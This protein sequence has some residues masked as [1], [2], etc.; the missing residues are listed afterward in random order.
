MSRRPVSRRPVSRWLAGISLAFF[1]TLLLASQPILPAGGAAWAQ[2]DGL[3]VVVTTD[4]PPEQIGPDRTLARTTLTVVDASGQPVPGAYL[5]LHLDA[6][7][8]NPVISTDFPIVEGTSLL[9]YAGV[10]PQG[11]LSFDYIYAIRGQYTFQ[12]EAGRDAASLRPMA[13]FRMT[14]RE[15][16]DEVRN[17]LLLVAGLFLFG[18]LAGAIIAGGAAAQSAVALLLL[19]LILFPGMAQAHSNDPPSDVAPFTQ[20]ARNGDLTLVYE[21]APGAGK[22]GSINRLAFRLLDA[23]GQPVPETT[24]DL[25]L[26]HV[27]DDKPIFATTLFAPEGVTS[28][29]F[30]FFDGAEHQVRLS[31][32]SPAGEVSLARVVEVEGINPPMAVKVKTT[33]YMLL[34]VLIGIL[35]GMRLRLARARGRSL[36]P[37][38]A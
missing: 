30:Q 19:G 8:G 38:G 23:Q 18:V 4:P 36:A 20:E 34:L 1:L 22:V 2:E 35:V 32:Q 21:M 9:E 28:L 10:L 31:A 26:W 14:L 25:V 37:V 15:N 13:P 6:P 17:F 11:T 29:D 3:Q 27:E 12:M 7:Q 24:F 33:I 5:K 16:P